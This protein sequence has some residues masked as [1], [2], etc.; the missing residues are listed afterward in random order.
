MSTEEAIKA[1]QDGHMVR[2]KDWEACITGIFMQIPS[3]IPKD[4]IPKMS[5]LPQN[6]KDVL[7]NSDIEVIIYHSQIAIVH[8][9]YYITGYHL[10]TYELMEGEWEIVK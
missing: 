5:S 4:V 3:E 8:H 1:M 6:V 10:S 9:G 2:E 7:V